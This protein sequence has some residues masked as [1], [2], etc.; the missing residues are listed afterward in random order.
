MKYLQWKPLT[1]LEEAL[2]HFPSFSKGWDFDVD[3]YEDNGNVIVEMHV[4]GV[5]PENIDI[6]VNEN[7]LRIA[8]S[9]EQEKEKEGKHFFHKEINRGA[10]ER[11]LL[12]PVD[13]QADSAQATFEHGVLKIVLQK[14]KT[15]HA[16]KIKIKGH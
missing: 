6:E 8:G 5:K 13:I 12:L 3:M 7:I 4:S 15:Q 16:H 9:R 2:E 11:T 1:E 14:E 10:F